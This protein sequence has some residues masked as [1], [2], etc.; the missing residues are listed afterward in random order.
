MKKIRN[1]LS[2]LV[3]FIC[4]CFAL[5][6]CG[7]DSDGIKVGDILTV[8]DMISLAES[9]VDEW[10]VEW[11]WDDTYEE[12]WFNSVKDD[13]LI[14]IV[15]SLGENKTKVNEVLTVQEAEEKGYFEKTTMPKGIDYSSDSYRTSSTKTKASF[16]YIFGELNNE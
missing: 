5:A 10:F 13:A 6:S 16:R 9:K 7:K 14:Y 2:L 1:I 11:Q 4:S 15:E 12:Y 8:E 3:V